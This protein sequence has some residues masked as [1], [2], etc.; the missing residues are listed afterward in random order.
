MK[1]RVP[2]FLLAV[3]L[4]VGAQ[5]VATLDH[6]LS[7]SYFGNQA[8]LGG[9]NSRSTYTKTDY[10]FDLGMPIL[11]YRLG[12]LNL[13][14]SIGY[15]R[16]SFDGEADSATGLNS[17]SVAGALFPYQPYHITFDVTRS[18]A[19]SLFGSGSNTSQTLGLDF[20]YRGRAIQDIR[21]SYRH[22]DLSGDGV[23][24]AFDSWVVTENERWGRTDL[25]VYGDHQEA[26]FGEGSS[27]KSSTFTAST[28]TAL[29]GDWTWNNSVSA[30]DFQG[31]RLAQVGT[32]LLGS[33]GPWTSTT[34]FD[35]AFT[36]SATSRERSGGL[37]QSL[38]RTWGRVS[39]FGIAGVTGGSSS[40]TGGTASTEN[41]ILGASY[42]L[43][44]EWTLMGDVSGAWSR[45]AA[46]G[47]A[48]GLDT[49]P[50][51]STHV[52]L[53]WGGSMTDTIRHAFFFWSDL[54]FQ[55]RIEEDYPPDY[56]P[57]ELAKAQMRRRMDQQGSL[58][59]SADAY[60]L[61]N[62]GPG[63]QQW[64][65]MQGGLNFN[66]GLM[67]QTIGDL[68]TDDRF[69]NRELVF[70]NEHLMLFGAYRIGQA[71]LRFNYGYSK[72]TVRDAEGTTLTPANQSLV[73]TGGDRSATY[74][75]VGVNAMAFTIPYGVMV[76]RNNDAMG[77]GTTSVLTY[78]SAGFRKVRFNLNYQRGWRTDGLRTSQISLQLARWF[79]TI[80][81]WGLG[82]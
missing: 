6:S 25:R 46:T 66:N 35:A 8:S 73:S 55:R 47:T 52:G 3:P 22:G 27:W 59:F 61:E 33:Q 28:R 24:G 10:Q 23:S 50:T 80:P 58:Q 34:I 40:S 77:V 81:V 48:S 57:P 56:L 37:S 11:A 44:P 53:T 69:S 12:A 41:L 4:A 67:L 7:M 5:E 82:D 65:R 29:V 62:G 78:L 43:T 17:V 63:H 13:G 68:R 42:R 26:S 32:S 39:A 1:L 19:P 16:Q 2:M 51:R 64:F 14:G 75:G 18:T 74:Y 21:I 9:L 15:V 79:D 70:R 54:R 36:E 60:R 45:S 30:F 72:A 31:T 49:G 38:A 71:S 20:L 76:L